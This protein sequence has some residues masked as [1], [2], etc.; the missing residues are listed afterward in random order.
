MNTR[1][2][3]TVHQ[4]FA[5]IGALVIMLAIAL[6]FQSCGTVAP[7]PGGSGGGNEALT[8]INE[9]NLKGAGEALEA[10]GKAAESAQASNEKAIAAFATI[11][12]VPDLPPKMKPAATD[13]AAA[14]AETRKALQETREELA[15]VKSKGTAAV[16]G[17]RANEA[18][19]K[20]QIEAGRQREAAKDKTIASQE[21][22][23]NARNRWIWF[24]LLGIGA[25][26]A[27][28]ALAA[29]V[30]LR[31]KLW[32]CLSGGFA[33]AGALVACYRRIDGLPDWYWMT[34]VGVLVLGGGGL[35]AYEF[36]INRNTPAAGTAIPTAGSVL[37]GKIKGMFATN[38][39]SVAAGVSD[40]SK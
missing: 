11:C 18:D 20:R 23:L 29:G 19:Y 32:A 9:Q 27:G 22:D 31:S 37:L 34:L 36:I 14:A 26:G 17:W 15:D 28:L 39:A 21:A 16:S 13:G 40:A 38:V 4:F 12:A 24:L 10:A 1:D 8:Q 33:T 7:P 3:E 2:R 30:Y 35:A 25:A 5:L 6:P